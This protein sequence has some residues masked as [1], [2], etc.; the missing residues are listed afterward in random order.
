VVLPG[1]PWGGGY[2]A[3]WG[4]PS[5]GLFRE[6]AAQTSALGVPIQVPDAIEGKGFRH[7]I[8]FRLQGQGAPANKE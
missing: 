3:G 1:N 7:H 4:R 5:Q 6:F 8:M 2:I